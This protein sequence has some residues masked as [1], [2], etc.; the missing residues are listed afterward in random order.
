[1]CDLVKVIPQDDT[2][3]EKADLFKEW[4]NFRDFAASRHTVRNFSSESIDMAIII[5]SIKLAQTAPSACNRQGVRVKIIDSEEMKTKV[6]SIQNGNRGFGQLADKILLLTFEQGS[7]EYEYRAS[8]YIDV[9]IF[10]MNLLYALHVNGICACT[11]NAHLTI[12][13]YEIL[14]NL[15]GYNKSEI[16]VLFIAIGYPLPQFQIAKSE[17]FSTNVI[18]QII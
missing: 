3:Y 8:G 9:G 15:L 10:A 13:Q 14:Q 6:L 17:R 11:L 12:P 1:M 7:C 16:P 4:T 2:L 18:Y 5:D